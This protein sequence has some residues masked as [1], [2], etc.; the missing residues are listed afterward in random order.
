MT[1]TATWANTCG[2]NL[3]SCHT[4]Q[5]YIPQENRSLKG[6][7]WYYMTWWHL[8]A[9]SSQW[10]QPRIC[11]YFSA[12]LSKVWAVTTGKLSKWWT[13]WHRSQKMQHWWLQDAQGGQHFMGKVCKSRYIFGF[14][15]GT[16]QHF[17]TKPPLTPQ[18]DLHQDPFLPLLVGLVRSLKWL[19]STEGL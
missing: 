1:F 19:G 18:L 4:K 10:G 11:V 12:L 8:L 7:L 6:V 15:L 14:I 2:D 17:P 13:C 9:I 16:N 3:I 5:H